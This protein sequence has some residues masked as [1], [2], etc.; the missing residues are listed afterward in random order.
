M[1]WT[2]QFKHLDILCTLPKM[3]AF[4]CISL[5]RWKSIGYKMP[6]FCAEK[7]TGRFCLLIWYIFENKQYFTTFILLTLALENDFQRGTF[8]LS[9]HIVSTDFHCSN[10]HQE[11][12]FSFDLFLSHCISYFIRV[13]EHFHL[14]FES[15][16][17]Q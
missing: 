14:V 10:Q 17:W 6:G 5:T 7:V 1:L 15:I 4:A 2:N 3:S 13:L 9:N 11:F 8:Y 12:L 16:Y